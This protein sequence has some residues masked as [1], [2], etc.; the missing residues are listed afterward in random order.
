[1]AVFKHS[2]T[3]SQTDFAKQRTAWYQIY[4]AECD[5]IMAVEMAGGKQMNVQCI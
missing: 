5:Q 3:N 1:M 2:S 4:T